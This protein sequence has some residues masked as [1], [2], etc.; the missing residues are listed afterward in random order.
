MQEDCQCSHGK[1]TRN[2]LRGFYRSN[3]EGEEVVSSGCRT[4]G[5]HAICDDWI[6]DQI[7][8]QAEGDRLGSSCGLGRG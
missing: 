7:D 3:G 4:Q 5:L 6:H 8:V 1:G 2:A